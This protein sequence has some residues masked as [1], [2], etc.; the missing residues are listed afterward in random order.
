MGRMDE[1]YPSLRRR[2]VIVIGGASGVT[3]RH[4]VVWS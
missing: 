1:R 4:P 3:L 2:H